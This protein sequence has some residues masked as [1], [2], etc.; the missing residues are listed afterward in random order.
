MES[1]YIAAMVSKLS[2]TAW[3]LPNAV[4][5]CCITWCN[6]EIFPNTAVHCSRMVL[7]QITWRLFRRSKLPHWNMK[8]IGVILLA[9]CC[10]AMLQDIAGAGN[11]WTPLALHWFIVSE[12]DDRA[13]V[14]QQWLYD[15]SQ[16]TDG[17][18]FFSHCS[19]VTVC[20]NHLTDK[21][22]VKSF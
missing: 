19:Q 7:M 9:S 17:E 10:S 14:A 20:R 18:R 11:F 15:K 13:K 16:W 8:E 2:L 4:R 3:K 6:I 22:L 5:L 12:W 1:C 21:A